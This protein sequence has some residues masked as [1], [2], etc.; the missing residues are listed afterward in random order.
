MDDIPSVQS[1]TSFTRDNL[2]MNV[3]SKASFK[4]VKATVVSCLLL[5]SLPTALC[6]QAADSPVVEQ[7]KFTLHKFEQAIGEETYEIRRDGDS[8]AT[9]VDF[10][11]TDRGSPVPLSV[12]FRSAQDLTPQSFEIKGRTARPM[13][14]DEAVSIQNGKAH[15]RTRDKQSDLAM[16]TGPFFTIAG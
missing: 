2:T 6:Q 3:R 8:L 9:K 13:T 10:K 15:L 16:P 7:G 4:I 1:Q 14:I 12:T 11:F 5:A